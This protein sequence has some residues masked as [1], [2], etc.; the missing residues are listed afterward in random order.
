MNYALNFKKVD[1]KDEY[2][3]PSAHK[4]GGTAC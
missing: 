2:R 3:I 1:Y 4:K